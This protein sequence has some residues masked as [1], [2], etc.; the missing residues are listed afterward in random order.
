[1]VERLAAP[2]GSHP[3]AFFSKWFWAFA[4]A[5]AVIVALVLVLGLPRFVAV[6]EL[7]WSQ[8]NIQ[9]LFYE[10]LGLSQ[11]WSSFIAVVGSFF[12]ALAWVPLLLWTYR[13]LFW[14]F[15]SGQFALAFACWV[16]VYGHVPLLHALLGTDTCFNQRT[17]EPTKWYVQDADGRIVLFDSG[18][19]DTASGA[20]KQPVTAPICV[21]FE[22]QKTNDRPRRITVDVR[23]VEFFDSTTGRPRVWYLKAGDGS[24]ELFDSRGYHPGTSEALLPMTKEAVAEIMKRIADEEAARRRAEEE[25]KRAEEAEARRLAAIRAQEEAEAARR[26]AAEEAQAARR[27]AE[28]AAERR[29]AEF[30]TAAEAEAARKRAEALEAKRRAEEQAAAEAAAEQRRVAVANAKAWVESTLTGNWQGQYFYSNTSQAPVFFRLQLDARD[31]RCQGRITEPNT[32]PMASSPNLY[33]NVFCNSADVGPGRGFHFHKQ[34][35]GTGGVSHGVEYTG[36]ISTDG[37]T[38]SGVWQI[39][40]NSG[41]FNM[42]RSGSL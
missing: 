41:R 24:F 1:M 23:Q 17:G 5:F 8:S 12:Y 6:Y 35:D 42:S 30:R 27:R 15:N 21:A 25:R 20:E 16:F 31:G 39:G 14:R 19:F 18:G 38:I 22:R 34:Y 7:Y 4:A 13:V 33:A 10:D 11:S 29:K 26:R 2:L 3:T 40:E 37:S 32:F 28:E 36:T 9:K